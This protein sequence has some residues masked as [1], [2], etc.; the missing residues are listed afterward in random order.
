LPESLKTHELQ[1]VIALT[2]EAVSNI[3]SATD[4][5]AA[6]LD[7]IEEQIEEASGIEGLRVLRFR[8]EECLQSLR[9]HSRHQKE[10]ISRLLAQLRE[11]LEDA[12]GVKQPENKDLAPAVDQLSGLDLRE[13]AEQ[14]LAAAMERGGPSYA[15]LFVVDRLHVIN[16]QFGYS[17]GD[18]VLR[19]FCSHLKS[20]L[21]PQ[22]RLFRWTGPAF[23]GLLDRGEEPAEIQS[24]VERIASFKLEATVQIGNRSILLPVNC[25]SVLVPLA[26][27]STL[28]DVTTR[29]DAFTSE[30][31][32]H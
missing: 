16:A 23:V 13:A 17:T 15:A 21:S 20:F 22:D 7:Q 5:C 32:H 2:T 27:A 28:A 14:A 10:E 26:E 11:Q 19:A 18:Q 3:C 31:V 1:H 12:K 6:Q 4:I 25:A 9:E 8:L 29:L 30:R 24:D